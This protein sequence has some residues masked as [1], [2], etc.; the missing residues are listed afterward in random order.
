MII[1]RITEPWIIKIE[2]HHF[3]DVIDT[4]RT[5]IFCYVYK[6]MFLVVK[7]NNLPC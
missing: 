5:K 1:D 6:S 4:M 2:D 3:L 7:Y